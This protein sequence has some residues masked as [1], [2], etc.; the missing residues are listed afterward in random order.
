MQTLAADDI[1][2]I[3][4]YRIMLEG[5]LDNLTYWVM[6]PKGS[7]CARA[8]TSEGAQALAELIKEGYLQEHTYE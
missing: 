8:F 7:K 3:H 5:K 2:V 1:G 4:P 6:N